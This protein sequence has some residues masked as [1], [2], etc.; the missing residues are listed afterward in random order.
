MDV[1]KLIHK[2]LSDE[3]IGTILGTDATIIRYSEL[4]HIDDLD[5][6]LTKIDKLLYS[7]IRRRTG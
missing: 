4:R 6:I 2:A 3:D 7:P 1:I 5:E